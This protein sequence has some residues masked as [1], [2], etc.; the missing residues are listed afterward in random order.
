MPWS[1]AIRTLIASTRRQYR[2]LVN[3]DEAAG[4]PAS[5]LTLEEGTPVLGADG[6]PV[7]EVA[8]VLA[9]PEKDI[10]DGIVIDASW[11]PGG[12]VF[13]DAQQVGEIGSD[14]VRLKLDGDACRSL[15]QPS[16]NPATLEATPDDTVKEGLGEELQEKLRRAWDL[17]SGKY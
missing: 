4:E 5:Y 17:I 9:D 13:A 16:A 12:H 7:G 6:E 8:C 15:P 2:G 11:L 3:A 10:F 1:S 14:A